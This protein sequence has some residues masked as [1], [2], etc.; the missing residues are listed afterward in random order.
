MAKVALLDQRHP[1]V[2]PQVSQTHL[3]TVE[4]SLEHLDLATVIRMSQAVAGELLLDRLIE[5][6]MTI[7]IEHAGA[8]RGLLVLP[9]GDDLRVKAEA[10]ITAGTVNVNVV[11]EDAPV[12]DLP[13]SI[14]MQ[15][16]RTQQPVILDDARGQTPFS[17][18]RYLRL[19]RVRSVLCLPLIKQGDLIGVLYLENSLASSVFTP[20]RIAVLKLLSSQIA[21]SLENARLYA[22]LESENRERQKAEEA[23]RE[24]QVELARV[25]RLTTIGELVAS[26]A[27]E[28][29]Q[30]LTAATIQ[31]RTALNWIAR[32]TPNLEEA[33]KALVLIDRDVRRAGDVIR[34]LHA[35]VTKS[36]PQRAW[37][38]I[39]DVIREVLALARTELLKQKVRISTHLSAE[40]P[41]IRGDRVQLMQVML[42]LIMNG[43]EA[44]GAVEGP[45][46][47]TVTSKSSLHGGVH[48]LV[49][50][51]GSGVDASRA[52]RVFDSFFTTKATGMG[53]GL[54][55][56]RSIVHAHDGRIW[57]EPNAP[58]GAVFQFTL[59][60]EG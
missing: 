1:D 23:L 52:D 46:D 11:F 8:D 29:N 51:T 39:N 6:L 19:N 20:S 4:T 5:T 26:I 57:V 49:A 42:N 10:K 32:E 24:A 17:T 50:D 31:G 55:I 33:R 38:D 48:V 27:H 13:T 28:L 43:V 2:A 35:M 36:G 14:L 40:V 9:R 59:P 25:T 53:M 16:R 3:P 34:S 15:V 21:I 60:I 22:H 56:C 45:R 7:A 18:D 41:H 30:P 54:S 37:F 47:L 12:P 44:M 58:H